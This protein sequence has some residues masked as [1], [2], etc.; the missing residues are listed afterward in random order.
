MMHTSR[1]YSLVVLA[2]LCAVFPGIVFADESLDQARARLTPPTVT[3][4]FDFPRARPEHYSITVDSTGKAV[5]ESR[6]VISLD[7]DQPPSERYMTSFQVSETTRA[8]IFDSARQ[9]NHFQGDFDYRKR[10]IAQMGRKALVWESGK[11]RF[12]T[13]YNWSENG[14]I[15]DLTRLFQGISNTQVF[16]RRLTALRRH[17]KLGLEAEL[18]SMEEAAKSSPLGLAELQTIEPLLRSLVHDQAVMEIARKRAER[19]LRKAEASSQA[20]GQPSP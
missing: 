3:F 15:D 6:E 7:A 16:A 12:E 4:S 2:L 5:Y 11:E 8:R 13:I 20:P 14:L 10:R 9:L 1:S 17:D 19:L 18:K